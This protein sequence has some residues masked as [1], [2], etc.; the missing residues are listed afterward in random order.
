MSQ[1]ESQLL[2]NAVSS[3]TKAK[4]ERVRCGRTQVINYYATQ[5]N[6][7]AC[8]CQKCRVLLGFAQFI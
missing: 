5:D 7:P 6:F 3:V 4:W 2:E 1:K 8:S